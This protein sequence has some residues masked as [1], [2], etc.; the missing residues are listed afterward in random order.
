MMLTVAHSLE[1]PMKAQYLNL[2]RSKLAD[3][4]RAFITV[5][6]IAADHP[7]VIESMRQEAEACSNA[8]RIAESM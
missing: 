1:T 6:I 7:A 4:T 8:L 5:Q 2:L 3:A